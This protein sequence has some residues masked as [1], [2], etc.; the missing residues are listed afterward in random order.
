VYGSLFFKHHVTQG[1]HECLG[2]WVGHHHHHGLVNV[3]TQIDQLQFLRGLEET[4]QCSLVFSKVLA[5][6]RETISVTGDHRC[7]DSSRKII[8]I[9]YSLVQ[10]ITLGKE[11]F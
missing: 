1:D 4:W 2:W 11:V 3:H 10:K 6:I 7:C 9:A 5:S 8:L